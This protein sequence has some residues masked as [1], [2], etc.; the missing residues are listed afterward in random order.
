MLQYFWECLRKAGVDDT[1]CQGR[2]WGGEG[3]SGRKP[4]ANLSLQDGSHSGA[5]FN[6]HG[7]EAKCLYVGLS[8]SGD[9]AVFRNSC[10]FYQWVNSSKSSGGI[11]ELNLCVTTLLLKVFYWHCCVRV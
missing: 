6:I 5:H 4:L 11:R 8:G 9:V 7:L 10:T 3:Q 1:Q 2:G